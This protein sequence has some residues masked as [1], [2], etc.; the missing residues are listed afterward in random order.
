MPDREQPAD[1]AVPPE[2]VSGSMRRGEPARTA[3]GWK[4]VG[5]SLKHVAEEPG[6][7]RGTRALLRLNQQAGFDCPSC[8]WPDPEGERAVAEFCENGA[9]AVASETTRKTIGESFFAR[10]A[11]SE[12]L[13]QT[14]HWLEK[15][16]RLAEP[17]VKRPGSDH[18][19]PI[20]WEAAFRLAGEHLN[21]LA[22]PD[23]A[24]FYTS[25]RASNEAAF[26]YQL[27]VRQFGTNNLPD[28][29]NM[30]HES[31][32][33][34]LKET[35]GIGKGTVTLEDFYKSDC[36]VVIGQNPGTNHPRMLSALQ[37]AVENGAELIAI[38]P[39]P[40]TGLMGFSH[41]QQVKGALG[42]RTQLCSL[43]LPVKINGD[44]AALTGIQKWLLAEA[45]AG[46][47]KLADTFIREQTSSFEAFKAAVEATPWEAIERDSGLSRDQLADAAARIARSR[48]AIFCWAMGLTQ[49]RNAVGTIQSVV[50]LALMGGH[51]G[52]PGAGLCPVRGHSNVQG[53]RTVGVWEKMPD[54]F[55]DKLGTTFGFDPPRKHGFD[56][57][58]AIRAMNAGRASVFVALGGNFL[59]ATPDTEATARALRQCRLTVQVSTKLNRSHLVTGETALILPCLGR[60]E[61]DAQA[62]GPQFVTMENSM[63]VVHASRGRLQ[64]VSDRLLSEPAIVAGLAS[65]ALGSQSTVD[66]DDLVADYDRIRDKIEAVVPGFEDYNARVRNK[67][68]F[69][70]PNNARTGDFSPVEGGRARFTVQPLEPWDLEPGQLLLMTIRSH[71]QFNTTIYGNDDRYRGIHGERRVIFLN[72]EDMAERG[73]AEEQPVD[74]TSH[75]ESETRLARQF[76][77]V[78]YAIPRGCA[79]AYFPETNV[80]V[81][82]DS[83]ARI[84]NTPTSKSIIIRVTPSRPAAVNG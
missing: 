59:S 64:P 47:I 81:P 37:K 43:H 4:A 71:D 34:A 67:D 55:L 39:L 12:L 11:V 15:Q 68:G 40:E 60:S 51:I 79:A 41:P 84:S 35:I 77:A 30:C 20:P 62:A 56:T 69:Y 3:A 1:G 66:W 50:N 13:R 46:R 10:Y 58:D 42:I 61:V 74:I 16:G 17:V 82:V 73:I 7:A 26:L 54:A 9:K 27:F 31:S 5:V 53:D 52:R 6:L 32:G 14:D 28:C 19:E 49:H 22:S 76:L 33:A 29:S 70:L 57:V 63:G 83:V 2:T 18:Y 65:A 78:P 48:A 36:I 25:G 38:N 75:W 21:G 23:E 8:A 72:P 44:L 80:L 24:V 45:E